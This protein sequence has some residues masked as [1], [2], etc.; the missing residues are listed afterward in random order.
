VAADAIIV[1]HE[2][3]RLALVAAGPRARALGAACDFQKDPDPGPAAVAPIRFVTVKVEYRQ[4]AGCQ[5][6]EN[7]CD[8]RV[9]FFGSWMRP[10]DAGYAGD[11]VLLDT[12]FGP[13][14]LGR[15]RPE[16]AGELA[17]E[18]LPAL[19]ARLRSPP[20]GDAVR[21]GDGARLIVGGQII[22]EYDTPGTPTESGLIYVDDN[23]VGRS[24]D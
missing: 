14:L 6:S 21:R 24:P 20:A 1:F 18:R 13:N 5:N 23:G 9:V 12:R 2:A 15:L 22:T 7:T 8:A 3:T 11:Q 10:R 4:P 17:A 19:R 16:R